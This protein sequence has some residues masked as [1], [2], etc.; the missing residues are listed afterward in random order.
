MIYN[1][2]IV[3]I[4]HGI[5]DV[6][7]IIPL[8][9]N[10]RKNYNDAKISVIV[11]SKVHAE[12]LECT[13]LVDN[14]YILN[15]RKMNLIEM[16]NFIKEIRKEKY[17]I[18]FLSPISNARLGAIL[19]FFLD[20]EYRVGEVV[21]NKK[22]FI[23]HNITIKADRTLHRVDRNLNLLKAANIQIYDPYPHMKINDNLVRQAKQKLEYFN[24]DIKTIGICIGTNPVE[25]RKGFKRIPYEAKKWEL[26]NYI[27]LIKK[28]SKK[29]NI[30]LIGGKK[31]RIELEPYLYMIVNNNRVANFIDKT[32]II[33]SAALLNECDLIIGADTGMLHIGDALGRKTLTIF[34]P[35]DP[36][37][38]GPYSKKSNNITL[39]IDCQYCYESNK[40]F[41]CTDRK[42]LKNITV[43]NIFNY[44]L[45]VFN[46]NYEDEI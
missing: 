29:Y 4:H 44:V 34:G 10:L 1:K 39:N 3:E 19:L 37:L 13:G 40:V 15:I 17:D 26:N 28:L 33:E 35:T 22:Y 45:E 21:D 12:I 42:C 31:E 16:I 5:G 38:V 25:Q 30:I 6:V 9:N 11:A 41:E 20:C 46:E 27:N 23:N 18:G 24:K 8:I 2:I 14:Y 43:D 7:Q 36:N 32:T